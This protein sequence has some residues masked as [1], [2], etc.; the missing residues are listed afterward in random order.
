MSE[1]CEGGGAILFCLAARLRDEIR[2]RQA[3]V[4]RGGGGAEG[5]VIFAMKFLC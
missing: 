5:E 1:S 3:R 4:Y 2:Y